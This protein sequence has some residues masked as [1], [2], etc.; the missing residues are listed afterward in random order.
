ME[1]QDRE[2]V[3]QRKADE[4]KLIEKLRFINRQ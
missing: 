3:G 2:Q 4:L 1:E